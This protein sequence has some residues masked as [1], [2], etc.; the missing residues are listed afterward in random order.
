MTDQIAIQKTR[1][2]LDRARGGDLAPSIRTAVLT[3]YDALQDAQ[4]ALDGVVGEPNSLAAWRD[5]ERTFED[6]TDLINEID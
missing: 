2:A 1:W 3:L 5:A 4:S 6:L